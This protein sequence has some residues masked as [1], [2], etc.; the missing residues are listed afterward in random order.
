MRKVP[1]T[2][3]LKPFQVCYR[4]GLWDQYARL[5]E[6]FGADW[7]L[8]LHL[9][10]LGM[11]VMPLLHVVKGFAGTARIRFLIDVFQGTADQ[12]KLLAYHREFHEAGDALYATAAIEMGVFH[13][14]SSGNSLQ[15]LENWNLLVDE[16]L[17]LTEV[18]HPAAAGLWLEKA[19]IVMLCKGDFESALHYAKFANNQAAHAGSPSLMLRAAWISGMPLTFT[20]DFP[21]LRI[22]VDDALP[23][24][25]VDDASFGAVSQL[26]T[27]DG[28]LN[29]F[30]GRCF[31]AE[32]KFRQI[33]AYPMAEHLPVSA[34][35]LISGP[36]L[37]TVSELGKKED[38]E[39]L[40]NELRREAV[41]Q[42]NH[43]FCAC[44]H[45]CLGV[46]ELILGRPYEALLHANEG[47]E[48]GNLSNGPLPASQNA[49][50][51]AQALVDL[52]RT[53]EAE[54]FLLQ[55]IT[56]WRQTGFQYFAAC[57]A[58]EMV[59]LQIRKGDTARAWEFHDLGMRLSTNGQSL[60]V[61]NR[62][63]GFMEN[64]R[65][66]LQFKEKSTFSWSDS[67][68]VVVHVQTLGDFVMTVGNQI[69]YDRKWRGERTKL[70]LKALIVNGG[71][72][73]SK[74]LLVD[75]LWPDKD[76]D[77]AA[78]NLKV[79][80]SRLRK[81]VNRVLGDQVNWLV[82]T[83]SRVS[84]VKRLCRVDCLS[85]QEMLQ[86]ALHAECAVDD[87]AGILD[88]YTGDFIPADVT[89]QWIDEY[90]QRLRKEYVQGVV[91]LAQRCLL[92]G[93]SEKALEYLLRVQNMSM[94]NEQIFALLMQ[95]YL[96]M[97][98]PSDALAVF[99]QARFRLKKDY[100]VLPGTT[101][102]SLARQAREAV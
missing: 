7:L 28:L 81:L 39:E 53:D 34:R 48:R 75:L 89:G 15:R 8:D 65:R 40:S 4:H 84:M 93:E 74:E 14:W 69:L 63:P 79:A 91:Y 61:V 25:A 47:M 6:D 27:L 77:M 10:R 21:A 73:V 35:L 96:N 37:M 59:R 17:K 71:T 98:Y 83:D 56:Q 24:C 41:P 23:L 32:D 30:E 20:G 54:S 50:V 58:M 52:G 3:L 102:L 26:K 86:D 68:G 11:H 44:V 9:P 2:R 87:L 42:R 95:T 101:L 12:E 94:I 13:I 46:Y 5:M 36:L 100:D 64:L 43:Y 90:R 97:G 18:S 67:E 92:T 99:R 88:G 70:L 78:N 38:A 72:K 85:F 80:I 66:E 29:Y 57:G 22:L 76:G 16:T 31:E 55:W 45:Y 49:L 82:V 1:L 60:R 62:P 51:A 33:L 19:F